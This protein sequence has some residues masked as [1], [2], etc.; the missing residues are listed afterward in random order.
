MKPAAWRL[1]GQKWGTTA[2]EALK[3]WSTCVSCF[4]CVSNTV[5]V[6]KCVQHVIQH[7]VLH[8]PG[9]LNCFFIFKKMK[10]VESI[11]G[12]CLNCKITNTHICS[13]F[14]ITS[15]K[16][17]PCKK[18]VLYHVC[19]VLPMCVTQPRSVCACMCATCA[20]LAW[21]SYH[22]SFV[23]NL[24]SILDVV[25][26]C[27]NVP[28]GDWRCRTAR[29]VSVRRWRWTRAGALGQS[30]GPLS[31]GSSCPP[32]T[33]RWAQGRQRLGPA[34]RPPERRRAPAGLRKQ[35]DVVAVSFRIAF[36]VSVI[37]AAICS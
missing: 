29:G 8:S 7:C 11:I 4:T 17:S 25:R 19:H 6:H 14:L 20:T 30:A 13:Q 12:Y 28:A 9:V 36:F 34:E 16:T 26:W 32:C 5:K 10:K 24:L 23:L 33:R 2:W 18:V 3:L 22:T 31:P 15:F 37:S 21:K 1:I 27:R 35:K